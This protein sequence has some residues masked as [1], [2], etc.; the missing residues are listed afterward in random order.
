MEPLAEAD[1]ANTTYQYD[2]GLANRLAAQAFHQKGESARA[3][4]HVEK[5]TTIFVRLRDLNALRESDRN[6]LAELEQERI[7]YTR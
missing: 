7:A 6:V 1:H 3:V 4:E 2:L 5:A